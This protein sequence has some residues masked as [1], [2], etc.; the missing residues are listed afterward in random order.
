MSLASRHL[1]DSM[2]CPWPWLKA[3]VLGLGISDQVIG[4]GLEAQVLRIGFDLGVSVMSV[5][6]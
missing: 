4:L 6:L 2:A 5:G 3:Q 1:E